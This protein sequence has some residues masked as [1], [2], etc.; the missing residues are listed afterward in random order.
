MCAVAAPAPAKH[1]MQFCRVN[2]VLVLCAD[3][4]EMSTARS[5]MSI[6]LGVQRGLR[7]LIAYYITLEFGNSRSN[8]HRPSRWTLGVCGKLLPFGQLAVNEV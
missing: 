6:A 7:A 4:N 3:E 2:E 5:S 1:C 8:E